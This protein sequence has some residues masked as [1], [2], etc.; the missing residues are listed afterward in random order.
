[1]IDALRRTFSRRRPMHGDA[2]ASPLQA[3]SADRF[4]E[5]VRGL[6]FG[7][8]A[9][10]GNGH[11]A[12]LNA[13]AEEIFGGSRRPVLGRVMIEIAPSIELDRRVRAALDGEAWHGTAEL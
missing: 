12:W 4:E 1:M 13:A 7:V 6:S 3:Q 11:L 2:L 10:D 8:M 5:I 9:F